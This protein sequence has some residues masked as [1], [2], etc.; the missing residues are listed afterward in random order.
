MR[1]RTA[2][3]CLVALVLTLSGCTTP[4]TKDSSP[5]VRRPE[6]GAEPDTL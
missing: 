4:A 5:V 6:P 1:L 3:A 2:S